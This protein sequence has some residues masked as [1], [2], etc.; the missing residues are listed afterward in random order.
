MFPDSCL[1]PIGDTSRPKGPNVITQ[2]NA[3]GT[4]SFRKQTASADRNQECEKWADVKVSRVLDVRAG[5]PHYERLR[6]GWKPTPRE[7]ACGLEA[8][9]TREHMRAGS[10]HH[11][12]SRAGWKPTPRKIACGLGSPHHVRA[13]AGWEAHTTKEHVQAGES[14]PR[15]ITCG[16]GSPHYE[17]LRAIPKSQ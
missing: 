15:E 6:A 10:P 11:E 7:I 8:H 5:S 13:H 12:R 3:M 16:L 4:F 17:R 14:T 1:L 9:T 2:G